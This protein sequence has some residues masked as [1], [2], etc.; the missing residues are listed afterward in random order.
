MG[1]FHAHGLIN[2]TPK[3]VRTMSKR[4]LRQTRT[5]AVLVLPGEEDYNFNRKKGYAV[6]C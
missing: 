6:S 3:N 5:L 4:L 1:C 2:E